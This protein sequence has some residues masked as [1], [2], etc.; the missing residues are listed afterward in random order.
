MPG[1]AAGKASQ[2]TDL[3]GGGRSIVALLNRK[4]WLPRII[5]GAIPYFYIL[6]GLTALFAT[7]NIAEWFWVLPHYLLFSF[8]CMHIGFIIFR[9]RR[10]V[11]RA[12]R[13]E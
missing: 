4:I 11:R 1:T 7:L 13:Q 12:S 6:V 3:S 10:R 2:A 9:H 5:Y 8:A